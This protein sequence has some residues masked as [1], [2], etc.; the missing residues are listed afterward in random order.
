M[1]SSSGGIQSQHAK[2][3]KPRWRT[4][5]LLSIGI[6]IVL[7][8][9]MT[10]WGTD[11]YLWR[12]PSSHGK[13]QPRAIVMDQLS[14]NYPDPAFT[15]NIKDTLKAAGYSVDY[16]GPSS[17]A[18]DSFRQLPEQGYDLIIIRAHT[19]SSQSIITAE[20]YSKSEFV[21]DQL[22]GRLVPAQVD[23]GPWFFAITPKFVRQNMAGSFSESTILVMG[24]S[25]LEGTHDIASAFLD[26]GANFFV[27][28]DSSVS[29]IHTDTSTVTFVQLLSTGESVPEA[30]AQAGGSDPVYGA[31]LQ[32]LDWSTLVQSRV[33]GLID[34]LIVW[35]ALATILVIGPMAVFAAPRLFASFDSVRE[36]VTILVRRN[37]PLTKTGRPEHN[38]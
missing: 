1:T 34:K 16:S 11:N 7:I 29:I 2:P 30:T 10:A 19:G 21:A 31:R 13:S 33:S 9:G 32:Y 26:K 36:R 4:S 12:L 20:P 23:G 35:V 25:A 27:G 18:V 22:A 6:V 28:W 24:C 3:K 8:V 37:R 14:L 17:T 38:D 15:T 5:L